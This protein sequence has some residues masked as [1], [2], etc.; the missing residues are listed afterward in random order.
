MATI[1]YPHLDLENRKLLNTTPDHVVN[2]KLLTLMADHVLILSSHLLDAKADYL[3]MIKNGLSRDCS[4]K[5][6]CDRIKA[7]N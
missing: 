5:V 2:I 3:Y 6:K 7:W 1:Y 4:H